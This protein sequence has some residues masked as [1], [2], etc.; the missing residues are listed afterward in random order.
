L[1]LAAPF[2][3]AIAGEIWRY[4]KWFLITFGLA[5]FISRL[6]ILLLARWRSLAEVGIFSAGQTIAWVPQL[7]GTYLA[8]LFTPRI[9][10]LVKAG[11][12]YN[13]F[14]KFQPALLIG[15][16]LTYA[17]FLFL[18][19]SAGHKLLPSKYKQSLGIIQLLLPGAFSGLATFPLTIGFI[20]FLRPKFLFVMDCAALPILLVLYYWA[21][22]SYGAPGA[23]LVT[24]AANLSRAAIAQVMAW[25][26]A[27]AL[28][29][30]GK[31]LA[32]PLSEPMNLAT[33]VGR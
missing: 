22:G 18:A 33:E 13:F 23:A 14:R 12:F 7:I 29:P 31:S 24:T 32:V 5:A 30:P 25:K 15:C 6:D 20:M 10:P 8:V 16:A 3:R 19:P 28:N 1:S 9:M 27:R 11:R 4:G 26:W 2:S 17:I 21:I